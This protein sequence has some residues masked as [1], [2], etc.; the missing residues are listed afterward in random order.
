VSEVA[1]KDKSYKGIQAN[2]NCANHVLEMF[3]D[4]ILDLAG[5]L[6]VLAGP[7]AN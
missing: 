1:D 2:S 3:A 4:G 7:C 5:I 6:D